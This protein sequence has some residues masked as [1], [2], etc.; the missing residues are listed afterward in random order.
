MCSLVG[1]GGGTFDKWTLLAELCR[2]D[3]GSGVG[4]R[5][6]YLPTDTLA[7]SSALPQS[8]HGLIMRPCGHEWMGQATETHKHGYIHGHK[9][10]SHDAPGCAKIVS[11]SPAV[12]STG[13]KSVFG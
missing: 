3:L 2:R 11:G 1:L 12:L 5:L 6:V 8:S 10:K 7:S 4:P 9:S 13:Q